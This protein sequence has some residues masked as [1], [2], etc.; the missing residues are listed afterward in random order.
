MKIKDL[1]KKFLWFVLG[2]AFGGFLSFVSTSAQQ[3]KLVKLIMRFGEERILEDG[4][5]VGV[6]KGDGDLIVITL[7]KT[8]MSFD[9]LLLPSTST[10]LKVGTY[11]FQGT[12][13][14]TVKSMMS[15]SEFSTRMK[16]NIQSVDSEG[17]I[18]AEL[19]RSG[20]KDS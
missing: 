5:K 16:I 6:S 12:E 1:S 15:T 14:M 19:M 10:K 9:S 11:D 18:R 3:S 4:T 8:T 20:E 7:S 17:N 2:A 13:L